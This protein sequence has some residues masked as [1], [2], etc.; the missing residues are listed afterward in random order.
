MKKADR[1]IIIIYGNNN[2][3]S[4]GENKFRFFSIVSIKFLFAIVIVL[5]IFFCYPELLKNIVRW[6]IEYFLNS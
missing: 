5:A 4:I 6:I 3:V 2:K 1:P